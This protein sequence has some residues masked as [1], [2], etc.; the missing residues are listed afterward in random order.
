[1]K[2]WWIQISRRFL[3]SESYSPVGFCISEIPVCLL[4]QHSRGYRTREGNRIVKRTYSVFVD[5]LKVYQ[6][7]HHALKYVN[8]II[9]KASH[10]IG[11]CYG[12]S[13]CTEIIFEH[14]KMVI[15]EG[16]QVLEK[17][18][19]T[20]YPDENEIFGLLGIEQADSIQMKMVFE[21][22]KEEVSK[23]IKMIANTELNDANL[24]KA[25]KIKVILVAAYE[26]NIYRF[27]VSLRNW[28]RQLRENSQERTCWESRQV[29]NDCTW[30]EGKSK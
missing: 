8:E 6:E 27:N 25:I 23:R 22:V 26:M 3:Q 19:K 12:V 24:I 28:I 18:M 14:G 20:M 17:R 2:S 5:D 30:R 29:M 21:R 7:S 10:N 16:L 13:K 9:V 4:L 11:A 1:M 15:G